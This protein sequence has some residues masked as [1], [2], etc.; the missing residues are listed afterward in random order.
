MVA[1]SGPIPRGSAILMENAPGTL[2]AVKRHRL[3]VAL[4][5]LLVIIASPL[6]VLVMHRD[7]DAYPSAP[8]K[9]R[10]LEMCSQADPNFVRFRASDR[11]ACYGGFPRHRARIAIQQGCLASPGMPRPITTASAGRNIRDDQARDEMFRL[12][13][14]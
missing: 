11:A 14:S 8:E 4:A 12:S 13:S 9:K 7:R 5:L 10:A 2:T 3:T 6:A 1:A